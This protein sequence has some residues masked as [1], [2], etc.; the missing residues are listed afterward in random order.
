LLQRPYN[1]VRPHRRIPD[2]RPPRNQ[3]AAQPRV[4]SVARLEGPR[5]L[6]QRQRRCRSIAAPLRPAQCGE[7]ATSC[8][9]G[10]CARHAER[11]G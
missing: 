5:W 2:V 1:P 6:S 11:C 3:D 9:G 8:S 7:W 10:H 4:E